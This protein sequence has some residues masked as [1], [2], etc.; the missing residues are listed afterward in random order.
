VRPGYPGDSAD[1]LIPAGA[2]H[3]CRHR[4]W[5]RKVHGI[6]GGTRADTSAR[7]TRP[8]TCWSS[9]A[10]SFQATLPRGHR[11][12]RGYSGSTRD[13]SEASFD[14]VTV[15]QAWHWCDPLLASTE[16][17]EDPQPPRG[18]GP[19]LEPA[20]HIR[21]L[22]APAL[23]HHACRRRPQAATSAAKVGPEFTSLESHFTRWEDSVRTG[24]HSR[25]DEVPQLLPRG[26]RLSRVPR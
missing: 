25:A 20:G 11:L 13:C 6:A 14:V 23:T 9:S 19:D 26:Q 17:S 21:S 12:C 10:A 3:C 7:L 15:A 18:A 4:R 1:W 8:W 5:H 16:I 24:G 2:K 22:G